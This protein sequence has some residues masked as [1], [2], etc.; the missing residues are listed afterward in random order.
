MTAERPDWLLVYGDTNSTLAGALAASKLNVRVAHVES[1]PQA[2]IA[3]CPRSSIGWSRTTCRTC[4]LSER[5]RGRESGGG[6]DLTERPP[7]WRRDARRAPVA[8]Q[9]HERTRAGAHA[10]LGV[11]GRSYLLPP[12]TVPRTRTIRAAVANRARVQCDRRTDRLPG[13]PRAR[14]ILADAGLDLKP[15]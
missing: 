4:L 3:G 2:S 14:R 11:T 8:W 9:R 5:Y 15:T 1:G 6:R 13:H 12:C 7:R 10:R